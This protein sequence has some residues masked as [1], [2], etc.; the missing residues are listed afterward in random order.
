MKRILTIILL[1]AAS[2]WHLAFS[3]DGANA[4]SKV[5]E[6]TNATYLRQLSDKLREEA[7]RQ[8]AEA[9]AVALQ[10]NWLINEKPAHGMVLE[11]QRLSPSGQPVYYKT[12]NLEAAI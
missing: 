5:L 6:L 7:E 1:L 11:L 3:Q 2:G 8:K 4:K 12:F 9:R 10:K